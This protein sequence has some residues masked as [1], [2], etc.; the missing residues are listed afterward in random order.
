MLL[1]QAVLPLILEQPF[2]LLFV[3]DR[4]KTTLQFS[5][6]TFSHSIDKV[7][8]H[9]IAILKLLNKMFHERRHGSVSLLGTP[10]LLVQHRL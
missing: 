5:L 3:K 9:G 1:E 10:L 4:V 8:E 2:G 7:I 6:F